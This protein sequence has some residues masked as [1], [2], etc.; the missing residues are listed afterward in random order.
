MLR[1]RRVTRAAGFAAI[2]ALLVAHILRLALLV[3]RD[4]IVSSLATR[5]G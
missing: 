5:R 1:G 3:L 2:L 4:R